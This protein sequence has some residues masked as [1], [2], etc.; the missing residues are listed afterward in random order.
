VIKKAISSFKSKRKALES[1]SIYLTTSFL[2]KSLSFLLLPWFTNYLSPSDFGVIN[3][4]SGGITFL[5][6]L[7]SMGV[8]YNLSIDYYKIKHSENVQKIY[9]V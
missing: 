5:T 4:F 9:M 1:L 6:P 3:L 2:A 8:I 7:I